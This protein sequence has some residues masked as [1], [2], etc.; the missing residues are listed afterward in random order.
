M[1]GPSGDVLRDLYLG[2]KLPSLAVLVIPEIMAKYL[3]LLGQ[4]SQTSLDFTLDFLQ[5]A[6]FPL[7]IIIV[8]HT[9]YATK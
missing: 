3:L 8:F 5:L 9:L 1:N 2:P 4:Y 6:P 7:I